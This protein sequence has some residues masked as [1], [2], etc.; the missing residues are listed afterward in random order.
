M[1]KGSLVAFKERSHATFI[2]EK[3][4]AV[5]DVNSTAQLNY[6]VWM[7]KLSEMLWN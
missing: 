5:E 7:I 1:I 6:A 2:W 4:D 3:E